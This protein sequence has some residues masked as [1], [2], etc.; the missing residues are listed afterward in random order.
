[1]VDF[2]KK[3]HNTDKFRQAALTFQ[4][5]GKYCAYPNNTQE[6]FAY[7]DQETDRCLN[8]YTAED[9]D[10]ISGYNYFYLNYCPMS[11]IVYK[12]INGK[13]K[14]INDFTFP[15]FWDYDVYFF[16][17]VDDAQQQGKHLALLKSRRRG[18]SYKGAAMACRDY[19]LIP[20][21]KTFVY[22]ANKQYLTEDG[23]LTKA[24]DY[25][26]F[27]D[28]NTAWGKKRSV[29]TATRRRAGFFT[30]DEYGNVVEL[31]YKSEITGLTLKDNPSVIR[32]KR[33]TL[34]LFEEGGC[35]IAGTKVMM[36]DGSLKNVEDVRLND[37]LMGPD[38]TPRRVLQLHSGRDHMYEITPV[39]GDKQIVNSNHLIYGM[40]RQW[41]NNTYE[42]FLMKAEDYFELI[43]NKPYL[44]AHYSLIKT[45]F[46]WE[47][48]E[49]IIDP[50]LLGLWLGDG[51]SDSTIIAN[52]DVEIIE[53]LQTY[54]K[55]H[56]L[57][58]RLHKVDNSKKCYKIHL[59]SGKPGKRNWLLD[60]LKS[61][62]LINNK[63]IPHS[64]IYDSRENR[65]KL[66]A[67]LIDTDGW[68]EPKKQYLCISQS[69]ERKHIIY[70]AQFI[71]R[72]LGIKCTVTTKKVKDHR[73]R[74]KIIKGGNTEYRLI[75]LNNHYE[76]PTKIHRKQVKNYNRT[77][78]DPLSTRFKINYYGVDNY[79]GFTVD[80]DNL[81]V[82]GDFTVV[83][84]SMKEL[85]AAWQIARP[86]VEIDGQAFASLIVWGCVC[87][88]TK[89]YTN[90]G[91]YINVEDL[92]PEDGIVGWDTYQAVPQTISAMNKPSYK[93]CVRITTD[94]GRILECS[95]DHPVLWSTPMKTTKVVDI[96]GN[97]DY[98][99]S[100]LWHEAEKCKVGDHVGVIDAVP[101][102]GD[103]EMWE[104]RLV[105]WLI[106]DGSYGYDKTP[107]LSNCD[108]EIL[109][110]VE[111][112]F[113]T[114]TERERLTK[115]GR[116]YKEI[117]IKGICCKLR[118]LG[119]YGQT[120]DKK[121]LPADINEYSMYSL[122]EMLGGL[123]DTDGYVN[124]SK[125]GQ[126]RLTLTQSHEEILR[127]VQQ[128]LLKFGIHSRVRHIKPTG[129]EHVLRG[130]VIKDIHGEWRLEISD[131]TSVGRFAKNIELKVGYKDAALDLIWLYTANHHA[132]QQ[133]YVSGV[134]A[135]RIIKIED[136]GLQKIYN[137]TAKQQHNYLANGIITHNT[138]GDND[139]N[140]KTLKDMFYRPEGYNCLEFDNIWDDTV[141]TKKCGFFVPQWSNVDA[142]DE[143]GNRI[144]MDED[145]NTL[146]EKA[147]AYILEERRK[148]LE[149]ATSQE[150][151]DRYVCE[152]PCTP[153]EAML[154]FKGNIFP[155]KELQTQLARIRTDKILSNAKQV[156][157]LVFDANNQLQWI[158][159]KTGDV[160]HY[161]LGKDE[162]KTGSIVIWEHPS[163]D[164]APGL[165]IAGCL[166][167]NQKVFTDKGYIDVQD[168]KLTDKLLSKDG[169]F[170]DIINLQ[171]YFKV[172]EPIYKIRMS[173]AFSTTTF[174]QEHPLY[175]AEQRT[176]SYNGRIDET[177]FDFK[178]VKAKD[179][180]PGQWTIVPNKYIEEHT[181]ELNNLWQDFGR[182]DRVVKSPLNNK[183][184]WWFIGLWLGDGYCSSN[185]YSINVI[186][187]NQDVEYKN[188]FIRFV[189]SVL[190]RKVYFKDGHGCTTGTFSYQYL[191]HWLTK[192]FGK[193]AYGKHIPEFVKYMKREYKTVLLQGYLDSDGCVYECG[194]Y[195]ITGFVSMN[196][197]LLEDIQ[198]I[199]LSLGLAANLTKLRNKKES[200][201]CGKISQVQEAYQLRMAYH[202]SLLFK[203]LV[204]NEDRKLDKIKKV[205]IRRKPKDGC[206]FSKDLKFIYYKIREIEVSK[207]T[208]W[209]YNFEC[210]THTFVC[211][212]ISTHNCD[213]Y[214]YDSSTTD[215]LGSC[216]IYKRFQNFEEYSD[217]IVAEYTG[218]PESAND[219]YENVR[220][221]LLYYNATC[222]YENQNKGIFVYLSNKGYDYLL[223]DSPTILQD[224][225]GLESK[226]NRK[227]GCHMNQQIKT[228]GEGLIKEWLNELDDK[229]VKNLYKIM[230]EPLLEELISYNSDDNFDRCILKDNL[231]TTFEGFKPIQDIVVGDRVLTD[232]GV[233]QNVT[234]IDKHKHTGNKVK[235]KLTGDY[236]V[237]ECTDNHPIKVAFTTK[238][239][240][241]FRK[242]A[243]NNI[244]Y[245]RADRLNYKYQFG[246]IPKR[247][248]TESIDLPDD[249]LYLLGW[250]MS[251]GYVEPNGYGVRIT[252]Q[253]DQLNCAKK[254]MNIIEEYLKDEQFYYTKN[255]RNR[256]KRKPSKIFR[257]NNCW[258]LEIHSQKLHQ[259]CTWFGCLPNHKK[260][261]PE[262]YNRY[263]NLMPFIIGWLE[264]DGHQRLNCNYDGTSNRN[265]I[266]LSTIYEE[267]IHQCRQ[268]MIDH[269]IYSSIRRVK[270][271][272][273]Y[274]DQ[275]S[276]LLSNEFVNKVLS[277]YP[278]LKF[279]TI[280]DKKPTCKCLETE[281]GF[282]APIKILSIE[283]MDDYVYNFEVNNDHTY[284]AQGIV[285]HNCMSIIQ[286]MIYR[287]QLM[288]TRTKKL[289][290]EEKKRVLFDKP[291]FTDE[292]FAEYSDNSFDNQIDD[293]PTFTFN[294]A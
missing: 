187:D 100:W 214:D 33:A 293:I 111:E 269:G 60:E 49:H 226:V 63:H 257:Y 176:N 271:K 157:D 229:G 236:R 99:K 232:K 238:K 4:K 30:K 74:D 121:R 152:R 281:D 101:F 171:R 258:R 120:K 55:M 140:V 2:N 29:S 253:I 163:R 135:E 223:A 110:Y 162:D 241:C 1:M 7:W 240:H 228:W 141:N 277:Y 198:D 130:R 173:H 35:H 56:G 118:E 75:L 256:L 12:E 22:A 86:S 243:V 138:G 274:R 109:K 52:E 268:I 212:H 175:V 126:V 8:G 221:L 197:R 36:A 77:Q 73:L 213:S 17:A 149:N 79:Y 267:L 167:P 102:F 92:K 117:R 112:N 19:Y 46:D 184:F 61:L 203:Q 186:F 217:I 282:W 114:K 82:L 181:S 105:G 209:V 280:P 15:D 39:N 20:N 129:R 139:E 227:K 185:G 103:K 191:N 125:T 18:Y 254:C 31:G 72:S 164:A 9:G 159:K 147:K 128:V 289:D 16:Y 259:L 57:Y 169:S 234:W 237:L 62:N 170:V 161:P 264:G 278:S 291:L 134:R 279:I 216:F 71:A 123:F 115:D 211:R 145:G 150:A 290:E 168:V 220:K 85:S 93:E 219:F 261:N 81:F 205:K 208:G 95:K 246:L 193:Y 106:G 245:L 89:V 275:Y 231:I 124:V 285:V 68:Y 200:V 262:I 153:A 122:S 244:Q 113:D 288:T 37:E 66:L 26:D 160:T 90:N 247:K 24:W 127:Q 151:I 260:I 156:G 40:Y 10:W 233:I 265:G 91:D 94:T 284:V 251:D 286:L 178:F 131:I 242:E 70:T 174:T 119:I 97:T 104:P 263:N 206:F 287:Q 41:Y 50:Y 270:T 283:S 132:R 252:Y 25:M 133:K 239:T 250:V 154:S 224:T 148:V 201:I 137:L 48:N 248:L 53:Y 143:N 225:I 44:K 266:E 45:K 166:T 192:Y 182:I 158:Q 276:I 230:S 13:Q 204:N 215:S 3:F 294:K 23:I 146:T 144:C 88:G 54:A 98:K 249:V 177:K 180:K 107:R 218:R 183:E 27:I 69:S 38:G 59:S 292:W 43:T 155:K 272:V 108:A 67:G 6:Y 188:R 47:E 78:S 172:D 83:H 64:Y 195:Y 51:S 199:C 76:I 32:G 28:K 65:L 116:T 21:S 34:I 190:N 136:I 273:K 194:K 235:L 96:N 142:R 11:R 255:G 5:T 179:V 87:A 58:V 84:N 222:M 202:D 189:Q 14:K 196:L 80:K 42:P 165:Y 207:Y 210:D